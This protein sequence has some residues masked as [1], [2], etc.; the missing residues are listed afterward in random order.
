MASIVQDISNSSKVE[1]STLIF[2]VTLDVAT[3]APTSYPISIAGGLGDAA[4]APEDYTVPPTFTAGVTYD[5]LSG[6][7]TVPTGV[8][9][10]DV[11]IPT[12]QNQVQGTNKTVILSIGSITAS[13]TIV[14]DDGNKPVAQLTDSIAKEGEEL[15][16]EVTLTPPPIVPVTYS[17]KIEPKQGNFERIDYGFA[18][19]TDGV[20][21][22]DKD[23][24]I[25]V[26]ANVEKFK[27]FVPTIKN[28]IAEPDELLTVKLDTYEGTGTIQDE[29]PT[30]AIFADPG[31]VK[32][33]DGIQ[34]FLKLDKKSETATTVTLS[35][36]GT[37]S[38]SVDYAP[39][40]TTTQTIPPLSYIQTFNIASI[41][42]TSPEVLETVKVT[43]V[44]AVTNSK[45]ITVTINV[46][47]GSIVD[48]GGLSPTTP[49]GGGN[50]PTECV[51]EEFLGRPTVGTSPGDATKHELSGNVTGS[52]T[53]T[54]T[55]DGAGNNTGDWEGSIAGTN[56]AIAFDYSAHL[57]RI[58]IALEK[59]ALATTVI[60]NNTSTMT[61][62]LCE[63]E[64]HQRRMRNL[65]EG[66]GIH[67]VKP[68]DWL[69]GKTTFKVISD[70][71]ETDIKMKNTGNQI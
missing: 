26:P 21:F 17:F 58:V 36:A 25:T 68:T 65:G 43:I 31:A 61:A 60:A 12:I 50:I 71:E 27:I 57:S 6:T 63:I 37:A 41:T 10:F 35:A 49:G 28:D 11:I 3:D 56:P 51:V 2:T 9:T 53:G 32:E 52:F 22:N 59:L 8:I 24:T 7:I 45:P 47:T 30:I 62:K 44:S 29:Q 33:G 4:A 34:F 15:E 19:F 13:G 5:E 67:W 70:G 54:L 64:S 66:D 69:G 42:D 46:A 55:N 23:E 40:I 16:F 38:P 20:I 14:D 39:I 18:K 1:G 48:G